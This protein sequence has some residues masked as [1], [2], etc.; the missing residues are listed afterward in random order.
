MNFL[1]KIKWRLQ[2]LKLEA[3]KHDYRIVF[4]AMLPSFLK[5]ERSFTK[6]MNKRIL[7]EIAENP[8]VSQLISVK[9]EGDNLLFDFQT[10]KILYPKDNSLLFLFDQYAEVI[11]PYLSQHKRPDDVFAGI[12]SG[13]HKQSYEHGGV[14]LKKGDCVMDVGGNIGTFAI[15][16]A[17]IV[18]PEGSVHTFEPL[19]R[20]LELLQSNIRMNGV[21]G[22]VTVVPEGLGDNTEVI[23]FYTE[24]NKVSTS[25]FFKVGERGQQEL[26]IT[27]L[28][29]YVQT[30]RLTSVDFI[31]VDIEGM[32][33]E[34]LNGAR[35][36]II[37]YRPKIA[38]STY[39][40]KGDKEF[41]TETLTQWVP[42]YHCYS[43]KE[44]T[45]F[46]IEA[47]ELS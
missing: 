42:E 1:D 35:E 17:K 12:I 23:T 47:T 46:W 16:S 34:F 40:R 3:A 21:S 4:Q 13:F 20:A 27:T 32:E 15:Q 18:G 24:P 36:T 33:R 38:I 29:K 43:G 8:K 14:K 44:K 7:R 31:K 9:P 5:W 19:P 2:Y 30:N 25:S 41:I 37:K 11:F 26:H 10:M 28:D 39:H 22:N 6:T 45:Y